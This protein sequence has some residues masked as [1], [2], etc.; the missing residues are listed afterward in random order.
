MSTY[1]FRGYSQQ[2]GWA[3]VPLA[4]MRLTEDMERASGA[5][6]NKLLRQVR[7]AISGYTQLGV[8][9]THENPTLVSHGLAEQASWHVITEF[10]KPLADL[11]GF[12]QPQAARVAR[13]LANLASVSV[14][15]LD[16]TNRPGELKQH[17]RSFHTPNPA[18]RSPKRKGRKR[19]NPGDY[20]PVA[21]AAKELRV[22]L[23]RHFPTVK[24]SVRSK[25]YSG[26]ASITVSYTNGPRSADVDRIAQRFSGADFDPMIDL[27]TP[28]DSLLVGPDGALRSVRYGSDY[29]FVNRS[30]SPTL[31]GEVIAQ[32]GASWNEDQWAKMPDYEKERM[33]WRGVSAIAIPDNEPESV[34]A[35]RAIEAFFHGEAST[36][37]PSRSLKARIARSSR[38]L[39]R[40]SKQRR[41]LARLHA[42]KASPHQF[43]HEIHR[44][45]LR[46][47]LQTGSSQAR[48]YRS[49]QPPGYGERGRGKVW[50]PSVPMDNRMIAATLLDQTLG[51]AS[52]A[53]QKRG[54]YG[55]ALLK[56]REDVGAW[57]DGARK[58]YP[59]K[60]IYILTAAANEFHYRSR[61]PNPGGPD[62]GYFHGGTLAPD[63]WVEM[64]RSTWAKI[65]KDYKGFAEDWT[66]FGK[67]FGAGTPS[68]MGREAGGGLG[69]YPVR[70]TDAKDMGRR[71][72]RRSPNPKGRKFTAAEIR[73]ALRTLTGEWSVMRDGPAKEKVWREIQEWRAMAN[74]AD[75]GSLG[76]ERTVYRNPRGGAR[77]VYN[78]ILRG[79]YVLTGPH[80]TPISGRFDSKAEAQAWLSRRTPNP[81][82]RYN[83]SFR[84]SGTIE[85]LPD[86]V[87]VRRGPGRPRKVA[88]MLASPGAV[89]EIP[90]EPVPFEV[91]GEAQPSR[92]FQPGE[93]VTVPY[94]GRESYFG[95]KSTR[96]RERARVEGYTERE[97]QPVV[98]VRVRRGRSTVEDQFFPERSV[99]RLP[100]S[101]Y[102]IIALRAPAIRA[103]L[104]RKV[105]GSLEAASALQAKLTAQ[106]DAAEQIAREWYGFRPKYG[107]T[108]KQFVSARGKMRRLEEKL[109]VLQTM[110][111]E[112][113]GS[114]G[115]ALAAFANPRRNPRGSERA[116][117]I[118][119]FKKWHA[120]SPH[121]ITRVKAPSRI[122]RT[123]VQLGELEAIVY[124][125]D[126]WAGGPDNPKGKHILYEHTTQRPRPVL[127]TDPDGRDVFIVGGKMRV[128]ADGLVH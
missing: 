76:A 16:N 88:A 101:R 85:Q 45:D 106:H 120:F 35:R 110:I 68:V 15:L 118:R 111:G 9:M 66:E 48:A 49:P 84:L 52:E 11:Y 83:P 100:R 123:M 98:Q 90:P 44:H 51:V 43:V 91:P 22:T 113:G 13:L 119:T 28:R 6:L 40:S 93:L 21:E 5:G 34:T 69:L 47:I 67:H 31:Q 10:N 89:S 64:S 14:K 79:W 72:P 125:S 32:L 17:P 121:R 50:N 39:E 26:G 61:R 41:A 70:I 115:Q 33:A 92:G 94:S 81:T 80:Q 127:A 77:I 55:P 95:R 20:I 65:H 71:K 116:R 18:R 54:P 62:A 96:T 104:E 82:G 60:A 63:G 25:S 109:G 19:R 122:P 59:Q 87:P 29:V 1:I 36:A 58:R 46:R 7:D 53:M 99:R 24:F 73:T 107:E 42:G 97:G 108:N 128:T 27:K 56:A 112:L 37:N 75:A 78:R 38:R 23:K 105:R 30:V 4:M 3:D 8:T 74:L 103:R 126:K 102:N 12:R 114:R 86:A 117:G 124:R 2:R 57:L